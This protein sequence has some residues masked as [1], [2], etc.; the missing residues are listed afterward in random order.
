[1]RIGLGGNLR[2]HDCRGTLQEGIVDFP[3]LTLKL[4]G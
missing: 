1:M 3:T 2:G 4:T